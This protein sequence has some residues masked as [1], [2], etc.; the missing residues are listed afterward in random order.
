MILSFRWLYTNWNIISNIKFQF[1]QD[2]P[3][4]PIHTG[5]VITFYL[6]QLNTAQILVNSLFLISANVKEKLCGGGAWRET[7]Q[8]MKHK[9]RVGKKEK[10][11]SITAHGVGWKAFEMYKTTHI[12][13]ICSPLNYFN[14]YIQWIVKEISRNQKTTTI[15]YIAIEYN[16]SNN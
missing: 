4:N 7:W 13:F 14:Q 3:L 12:I 1:C 9:V 10:E 16:N 5:P 8:S 15:L 11:E 6:L 2:I